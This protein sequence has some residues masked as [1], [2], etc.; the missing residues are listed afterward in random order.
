MFAYSVF[1]WFFN[2]ICSVFTKIDFS[3]LLELTSSSRPETFPEKRSLSP[4]NALGCWVERPQWPSF[5]LRH[6]WLGII[7]SLARNTPPLSSPYARKL[8]LVRII[9]QQ[10]TS[11]VR[12]RNSVRCLRSFC[13]GD[14]TWPLFGSESNAV[15]M[16]AGSVMMIF[17]L[18]DTILMHPYAGCRDDMSSF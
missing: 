3:F 12:G 11:E 13:L 4:D 8:A 15:V 10:V 6:L 17:A 1:D 18:A 2:T 14:R 5:G 7:F 9:C 16:W